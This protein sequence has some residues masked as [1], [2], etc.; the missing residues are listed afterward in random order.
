MKAPKK[1]FTRHRRLDSWGDWSDLMESWWNHST[2][3]N[4]YHGANLKFPTTLI[5]SLPLKVQHHIPR[6][7]A[8][9]QYL[10]MILTPQIRSH[11]PMPGLGPLEAKRKLGT[12]Y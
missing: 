12:W 11:M 4:R 1:I 3:S 10:S 9:F 6:Q 8:E 2:L 5:E 7:V